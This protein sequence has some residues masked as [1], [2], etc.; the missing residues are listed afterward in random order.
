MAHQR[1]LQVQGGLR[2]ELPRSFPFPRD[3]QGKG[4]P[5]LSQARSPW[6]MG[7]IATGLAGRGQRWERKISVFV[8]GDNLSPTQ[9]QL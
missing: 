7:K 8:L 1:C 2:A 4:H 9:V 6:K 5:S 3:L